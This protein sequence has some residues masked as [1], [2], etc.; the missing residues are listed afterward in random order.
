MHE[1][2]ELVLKMSPY[3][4]TCFQQMRDVLRTFLDSGMYRHPFPSP[5][6]DLVSIQVYHASKP[7]KTALLLSS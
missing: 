2:R 6:S 7:R 5:H 3:L 1:H 4:S